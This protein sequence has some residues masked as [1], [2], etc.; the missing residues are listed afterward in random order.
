MR[1]RVT[2]MT[3]IQ[4]REEWKEMVC[5]SDMVEVYCLKKQAGWWKRIKQD[6]ANFMKTNYNLQ[7]QHKPGIR[8]SE[9]GKLSTAEDFL[10]GM[11]NMSVLLSVSTDIGHFL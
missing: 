2:E 6:E 3:A 7:W 5:K 9:G 4:V 10:I 1:T 11:H 8:I